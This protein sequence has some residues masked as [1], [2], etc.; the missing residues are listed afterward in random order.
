MPLTPD[1]ETALIE[2]VRAAARAEI[3]PRFRKLTD[4]N[5]QV[6]SSAHDL[7][8]IADQRAEAMLT[9]AM[10]RIL[11]DALVVGEE[12]AEVDPDLRGRIETAPRAVI[13]DP[14][15][16]TWNFA[17]GLCTFG[18][19]LAVTEAGETVF[20]LLYDPVLDDWVVTRRGGGTWYVQKD[21]PPQRLWVKPEAADAT[22]WVTMVLFNDEERPA[23]AAAVQALGRVD[24]LYCSCHEYRLTVMG[25]ARFTYGRVPKPWDHAAGHLAVTEAGGVSRQLDGAPY[26]PGRSTGMIVAG[27]SGEICDAVAAAFE[28][29]YKDDLT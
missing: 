12:A 5:V 28:T 10:A 3:M 13:I 19:I 2:A 8:T 4:D 22:G 6:K 11:P 20:G 29:V 21:T 1:E 24:S 18:V 16:G 27:A 9:E 23:V 26:R 17:A 25:K 15:D 7:V 14:V